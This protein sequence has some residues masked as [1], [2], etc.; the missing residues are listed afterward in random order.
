MAAWGKSR[1][2]I[3]A[4]VA[5]WNSRA[6][7]VDY[8]VGLGQPIAF[9]ESPLGARTAEPARTQKQELADPEVRA[10]D[11]SQSKVSM[12]HSEIVET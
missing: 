10:P 7:A 4:I 8:D 3:T 6:S 11:V 2:N 9:P 1:S 12:H 5:Q